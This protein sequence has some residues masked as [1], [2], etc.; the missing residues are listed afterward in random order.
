MRVLLSLE[1]LR[2]DRQLFQTFGMMANVDGGLTSLLDD[3][4][5]LW[6]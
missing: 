2:C 3:L 5:F 6:L 1:S 4:S